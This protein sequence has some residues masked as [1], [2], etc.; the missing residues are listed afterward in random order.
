VSCR[1]SACLGISP[2][3]AAFPQS[4]NS[5]GAIK[6][7]WRYLNTARS[8]G[9]LLAFEQFWRSGIKAPVLAD[10]LDFAAF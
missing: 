4:S 10:K 2:L 9:K 3:S 8:W 1:Q 7:Q 5:S 6:E